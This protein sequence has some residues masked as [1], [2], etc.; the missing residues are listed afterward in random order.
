[1]ITEELA[2]LREAVMHGD[3]TGDEQLRLVELVEEAIMKHSACSEEY[4]RLH[5]AYQ[6]ARRDR[7]T[8]N[9]VGRA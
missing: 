8:I 5:R 1:M 4:D 6:S 9:R 3:I 2:C 7:E